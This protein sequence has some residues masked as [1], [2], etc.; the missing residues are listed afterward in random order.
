MAVQTSAPGGP[1]DALAGAAP[2]ARGFSL[3][4]A[5]REFR[6]FP[7]VPLFVLVF[8]L[9]VP[10]IF[11][12]VLS[13]HDHIIGDLSR[14][15]EPP[16]WVSDREKSQVVVERVKDKNPNEVSIRNA[17]RNL[18]SGVATLVDAN[19]NG[20]I[21][22]G[23]TMVRSEPGGSWEYPFGTDKQGRDLLSRMMH[24]ARISLAV[25]C[26]AILVGGILGTGLG[27]LAAF[28]GGFLDALVMRIVDIKLAFP[29]ILLALTLVVAI[30][31]GFSTVII[32]IA[33]LLWA[34]YARVVRGEALAIRERDFI[35]RAR[36]AGASNL[37]IMGRHI[38]PNVFNTVI[39]LATLEVGHVIILEATLS[40]LGAGI[41]RPNPAWGL[42][43]ADG[44]EVITSSWWIFMF[45]CLAIVLTV[46]SMNLL[47]DWLRD[48]LDPKLRN[49]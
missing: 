22:V 12:D 20:A 36:V 24:G 32:V 8:L 25:S 35:D 43:A 23:E 30:G 2:A 10:A 26:L 42:M 13:P 16:G 18:D 4:R 6:R 40:F 1:V 39:V 47:G 19:G 34:R 29:S 14:D 38:F 41:P 49:V 15:L 37:R 21:D 11:A 46:L 28:R 27:M 9:I 31:S 17:Q 7:V 44:R 45:P 33:L 5:W 48:R 3:G